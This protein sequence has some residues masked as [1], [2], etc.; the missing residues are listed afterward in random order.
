MNHRVKK[1]LRNILFLLSVPLI[2]SAFVFARISS[3]EFVCNAL[4]ISISNPEVSFVTKS[5]VI[6]IVE[7]FSIFANKTLVSNL[8]LTA[9][10]EKLRENKWI[11]KA[12]TYVDA[13]NTLHISLEQK[14]PLVRVLQK[15]STDYAYYLDEY[16]NPIPLSAQY[17]PR[18]PVVSA[19]N[20]GY[21]KSDLELKSD[22][23]S[24][25]KYIQHDTFWNAAISQ[26]DVDENGQIVLI[27]VLGSQVILFGSIE[28]MPNKFDR[29]LMFYKHSVNK[30]DWSKIDELDVR[31]S[32]QVI[33]RSTN[34]E[35]LSI[36][37]YNKQQQKKPTIPTGTTAP[38]NKSTSKPK[39]NLNKVKGSVKEKPNSKKDKSNSITSSMSIKSKKETKNVTNKETK[40]NKEKT[41]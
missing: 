33:C 25:S 21:N 2:I 8:N 34:G 12:N 15:D 19:P 1:I 37:P 23:V 30:M 5:D 4:D 32:G 41:Q 26:I 29:L 6:E 38:Q 11:Q 27:P 39:L 36:D 40:T 20:L 22:L 13:E 28:N 17:S 9:L 3:Q 18:L 16:A 10:E 14:V 35:V 24:M 31:F 7:S